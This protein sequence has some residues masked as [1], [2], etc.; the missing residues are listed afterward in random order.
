MSAWPSTLP[1]P[2]FA[3]YS[4]K[5]VSAF[6]RTDMEAGAAR[7]RKRFTS[8]PEDVTLNWVFTPPEMVI[9]RTFFKT[10]INRGTDWFTMILDLGAGSTSYYIRFTAPYE[11][12]LTRGPYWEVSGKLEVRDA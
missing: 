12:V 11:A 2:R 1:R 9:F 3:G 7:Q 4:V 5:P 8:V 10:D 6:I